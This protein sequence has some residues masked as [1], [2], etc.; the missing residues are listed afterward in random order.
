MGKEVSQGSREAFE[1]RILIEEDLGDKVFNADNPERSCE[2]CGSC[3]GV[4]IFWNLG[5]KQPL[6][7]DHAFGISSEAEEAYRRQRSTLSESKSNHKEQD[8]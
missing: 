5:E 2:I 7:E 4:A 3:E 1:E 8:I 6:C